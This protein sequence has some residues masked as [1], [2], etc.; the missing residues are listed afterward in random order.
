MQVHPLFFIDDCSEK[1][2]W[3]FSEM[4]EQQKAELNHISAGEKDALPI[5]ASILW[6]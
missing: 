3:F 6:A 1:A 4:P 5:L 2:N